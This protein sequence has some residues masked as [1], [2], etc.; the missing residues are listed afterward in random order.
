MVGALLEVCAPA[1]AE[2]VPLALPEADPEAVF[3]GFVAVSE[4]T[5]GVLGLVAVVLGTAARAAH[6]LSITEREETMLF[7]SLR[8]VAVIEDWTLACSEVGRPDTVTVAEV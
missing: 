2:A 6:S 1:V 8:L 7:A 5:G 3:A 4:G